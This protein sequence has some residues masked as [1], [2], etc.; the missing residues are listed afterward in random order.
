MGQA[1]RR[2]RAGAAGGLTGFV[3]GVTASVLHSGLCPKR[4]PSA[5]LFMA[6]VLGFGSAFRQW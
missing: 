5:G 4:S 6:V 3:V 1:E 2:I